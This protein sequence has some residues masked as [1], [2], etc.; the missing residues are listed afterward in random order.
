MQEFEDVCVPEV[1]GAEVE[2][3]ALGREGGGAAQL[4]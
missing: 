1:V 4:S 3:D 2:F